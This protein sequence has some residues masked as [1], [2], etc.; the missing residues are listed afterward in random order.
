M[1]DPSRNSDGPIWSKKMNGPTICRCAEGSARRTSKLPRSR[2]RGT[3]TVS[4][5]SQASL[6][7]GCG[8]SAGFQLIGSSPSVHRQAGVM[9]PPAVRSTSRPSGV[10]QGRRPYHP[11]QRD[12]SRPSTRMWCPFR[13]A[14]R[15]A[16]NA[17]RHS[18]PCAPSRRVPHPL[19]AGSP[20][21]AGNA[22][23]GC[24]QTIGRRVVML[25]PTSSSSAS[26]LGL[27]L[28]ERAVGRHVRGARGPTGEPVPR[29]TGADA[30]R[31][32]YE[33]SIHAASASSPAGVGA[34]NVRHGDHDVRPC[35]LPSQIA[36]IPRPESVEKFQTRVRW[37]IEE[38]HL[39]AFALRRG[40]R[41]RD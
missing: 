30:G 36:A 24:Q 15:S 27:L 37:G 18:A 12:H 22:A 3:I 41:Y 6:S 25:P 1:P 34:S 11:E 5:A 13:P 28:A 31:C 16:R 26:A 35:Q 38:M 17:A 8:S 33:R 40:R 4:M 7:P 20:P 14:R 9:P 39:Q 2:A 19:P 21:E 23:M 10:P 32:H 29:P